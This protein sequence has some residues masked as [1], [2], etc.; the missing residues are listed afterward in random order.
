MKTDY[1][2]CQCFS[3]E[4]RLV[5]TYDDEDNEIYASIFLNQYHN[6]FQ[7]VWVGIKYIFGYKCRYGHFDC[8]ILESSDKERLINTIN[9]LK[10]DKKEDN[11]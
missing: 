8:F 4:N 6:F 9:Q 5:F 10:Y 2:E 1:F 3:S 11:R 7:R